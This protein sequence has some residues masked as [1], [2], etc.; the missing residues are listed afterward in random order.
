[1]QPIRLPSVAGQTAENLRTGLREGRWSGR[2][3]RASTPRV[4]GSGT[5]AAPPKLG[6]L[7]PAP[8]LKEASPLVKVTVAPAP[9]VS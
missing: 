5:A 4:P 2:R 1:M 6:T 8:P 9:M 3:R 7:P